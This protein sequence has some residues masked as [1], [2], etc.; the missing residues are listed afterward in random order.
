MLVA[1]TTASQIQLLRHSL[2]LGDSL[3]K[4]PT[5]VFVLLGKDNAVEVVWDAGRICLAFD[6]GSIGEDAVCMVARNDIDQRS[7]VSRERRM[8]GMLM[9][10]DDFQPDNLAVDRLVVLMNLPTVLAIISLHV[11]KQLTMST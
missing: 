3:N 10:Q 7:R 5:S 1:D 8:D 9:G 2:L 4:L 11:S 6:E